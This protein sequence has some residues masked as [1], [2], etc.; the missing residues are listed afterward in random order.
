[1]NRPDEHSYRLYPD[2]QLP[3]FVDKNTLPPDA[4]ERAPLRLYLPA[5]RR[6]R[7]RVAPPR[8][9]GAG[10]TFTVRFA[11]ADDLSAA[12]DALAEAGREVSD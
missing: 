1:M 2:R 5:R 6:R 3:N 9:S 10:C 12:L 11:T 7:E 8:T 4:T